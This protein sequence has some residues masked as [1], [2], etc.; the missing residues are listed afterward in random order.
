VYSCDGTNV[1]DYVVTPSGAEAD[2]YVFSYENGLLTIVKRDLQV[3]PGDAVRE[4]GLNNP[5]FVLSYTGFFGDETAS[6]IYSHPTASTVADPYSHAGEYDITCSGGEARNYNFVYETGKLTVTKAPLLATAD[7]V[8]RIY[9]Y[10]NPDFTVSCIGFRHDD[11]Q[12]VL[13]E[14]PQASTVADKTSDAGQYPI[15]VS[16]GDALDYDFNYRSGRLTITKAPLTV[17]AENKTRERGEVNPDF[18]LAYTGFRNDD[19]ESVLDQSPVITCPANADS[20][21]G[22]YDI[23]LQGGH[24]NNYEFTLFN[25]RLEVTSPTGNLNPGSP[26]LTVY[27]TPAKNR[28]YIRSDVPVERIEL[29]NQTGV[30]VLTG[31]NVRESLDIS[32]LPGGFYLARI[33]I[34]GIPQT[35]KVI[36]KN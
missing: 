28:L 2:N 26:E 24:D 34:N 1:G 36:I 27:P 23:E 21:T 10:D 29:Y 14:Q 11:T 12:A 3:I 32:F 20:P 5:G 8:Y 31:G 25:G 6:V 16:G 9:G 17:T 4:Y 7:N 19:D 33:Y 18:T 35:R 30:C 15:T 22:F 13:T